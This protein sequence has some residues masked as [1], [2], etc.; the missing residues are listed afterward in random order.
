MTSAKISPFRRC[1]VIRKIK[2][3]IFVYEINQNQILST[4]QTFI[5]EKLDVI[6]G[7]CKLLGNA[8]Y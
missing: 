5:S 8:G 2:D 6:Q 3:D 4:V 7:H 1:Y